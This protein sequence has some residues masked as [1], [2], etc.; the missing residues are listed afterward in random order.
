MHRYLYSAFAFFLVSVYTLA[1]AQPATP[2]PQKDMR[3]ALV[4][5]TA[6]EGPK[7]APFISMARKGAQEAV[8]RLGLSI[9]EYKLSVKQDVN[10]ML[11]KIASGGADYI[12][13]IGYQ[14]VMPVL[15]LAERFPNTRFTVID[16]LVPPLFHNVQSVMFKDHEG[17]FLVGVLAALKSKSNHIGFIGG[18]DIPLIRNFA[19][20]YE[21][22]ATYARPDITLNVDM[23]GNDHGAWGNSDRAR[24]LANAQLDDGVDVIF[25]AAGAAGI[26]AL[27]VTTQHESTYGIGVDSNQNALFPGHV[28]TSM[29]KRVDKAVYN[30]LAIID[31][32][33][34]AP[35]IKHLGLRDGVLD[36]AIDDHNRA[37]ITPAMIE[38]VSAAR[39]AIVNGTLDVELYSPR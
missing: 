26:A 29:V 20:G 18:V 23:I 27:E 19:Y 4:Y 3:I 11:T 39:E 32:D 1:H 24:V 28:L 10:G 8:E 9:K 12:V 31:E 16:G 6:D 36:Y 7:D 30:S 15:S 38:Q 2:L 14:N 25:T 5:V 21:Q 35:G 33:R 22:G 13:A 34:W 37:L 17:A